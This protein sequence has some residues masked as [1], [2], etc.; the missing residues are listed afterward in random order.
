M[1]AGNGGEVVVAA[2]SWPL[3]VRPLAG[4]ATAPP[5]ADFFLQMTLHR[6]Q[7]SSCW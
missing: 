2:V 5:P 7:S 3:V 4:L 6:T 1:R